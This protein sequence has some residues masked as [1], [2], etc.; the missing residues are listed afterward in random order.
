MDTIDNIN[1]GDFFFDEEGNKRIKIDE[2]ISALVLD[3]NGD[4]IK[5]E[6]LH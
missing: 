1:I 5:Q 2:G 3:E 6:T 4:V